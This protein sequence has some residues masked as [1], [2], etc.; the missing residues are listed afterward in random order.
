MKSDD[1]FKLQGGA[2]AS[3]IIDG[4]GSKVGTSL[5]SY[6]N[7]EEDKSRNVLK[8]VIDPSY[9][10]MNMRNSFGP[11]SISKQSE[12]QYFQNLVRSMIE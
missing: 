4:K 10:S 6:D 8:E 3:Q 11:E 9:Q 2:T 12:D 5:N 7:D 1:K